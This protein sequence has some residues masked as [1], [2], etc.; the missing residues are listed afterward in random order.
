MVDSA[1]LRWDDAVTRWVPGFVLREP[2]ATQ[3]LTV[4]DLLTHPAHSRSRFHRRRAIAC[5]NLMAV[6][7]EST[8]TGCDPRGLTSLGSV[9]RLEKAAHRPAPSQATRAIRSAFADLRRLAWWTAITTASPRTFSHPDTRS[10]GVPF[11]CSWVPGE[12]LSR[13]SSSRA[14]VR[15]LVVATVPPLVAALVSCTARTP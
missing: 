10:L 4:H 1:K 11:W 8:Y 9:G 12:G 14:V 7:K 5:R 3:E 2:Y 13:G 6:G 15:A